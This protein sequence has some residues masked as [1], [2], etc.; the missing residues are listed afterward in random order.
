M[1]DHHGKTTDPHRGDELTSESFAALAVADPTFG[2][3]LS[4]GDAMDNNTTIRTGNISANKQE[5]QK[6]DKMEDFPYDTSH[7]NGGAFRDSSSRRRH[8]SVSDNHGMILVESDR[9]FDE[10]GHETSH[11]SLQS[12]Y[13][14]QFDKP[15]PLEAAEAGESF[16]PRL[17]LRNRPFGQSNNKVHI[18]HNQGVRI[19]S[20]LKFNWFHAFLRWPTKWSLTLLMVSWTSMILFFALLYCWYDRKEQTELCG[21]GQDGLPM[22]FGTAFAF[23]LETCT[24]V[25]YG[26]PHGGNGFFEQ[27]C[28]SLQ[29][30]IYLQ[31]AWSMIFNAFLLAFLYARLGRSETR[32]NQVINSRKALVSCVDGQVRF[33][34]RLFD[35]D[36]QHP[37]VEAHV[38]LYCVMN[39]RPVPRPLRLLQPDDDMGGMLF[40][41]FPTVVSHHIDLYS[42]LHP[43]VTP[44]IGMV[45]PS[46]LV[47]KQT[48]GIVGNRDDVICPVCGESYGTLERW[49]NHVA[50]QQIVEGHD[51]YPVQGTHLSI[52]LKQIEETKPVDELETLKEYFR[53]N[54]SEVICVVEGIDPLQSGT[55][56]SL[57]SYRYEDIVWDQ[58]SQWAPCLT[59]VNN[60]LQKKTGQRMFQIDLDRYHDIVIDTAAVKEERMRQEEEAK[61]AIL[62]MELESK[63]SVET[64]ILDASNNDNMPGLT[65]ALATAGSDE[66]AGSVTSRSVA[67]NKPRHRRV[68]SSSRRPWDGLFEEPCAANGSAAKAEEGKAEAS[69]FA[70]ASQRHSDPLRKAETMPI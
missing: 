17:I 69:T 52:D 12:V 15:D 5:R 32:S 6:N 56:Q 57:Q 24:T 49:K 7:S 70:Q 1:S 45:V 36:A 33:Q 68:K 38:R 23:S 41:S 66:A 62:A 50:Y 31:M 48:D 67:S 30:L 40:L 63:K 16:L 47:L 44:D 20:L 42:L 65:D 29:F 14:N 51:E 61:A 60:G 19:Y 26:L 37:V 39:H 27:E 10:H 34:V 35:A 46:G 54:V 18:E 11:R 3:D 28:G 2:S 9:Q 21:L 4:V 25:G 22:T 43:P 13:S 55:F 64:L 8:Q 59:I 58:H 53:A